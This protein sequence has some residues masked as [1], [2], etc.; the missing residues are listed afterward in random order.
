MLSFFMIEAQPLVK[1]TQTMK[2]HQLLDWKEIDRQ[3]VDSYKREFSHAGGPEPFDPLGMFKLMLLGQWHGL[4]DT[5]LERALRVRV[6]VD[7]MVFTGFE[8][9]FQMPRRSAG[10]A[11]AWSWPSSIKGC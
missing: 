2:L 10:S 8:P 9:G 5:E 7:F 11:I 4:S 3:L 6:R 1:D